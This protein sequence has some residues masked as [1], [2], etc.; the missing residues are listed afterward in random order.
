MAGLGA[1]AEI[2]SLKHDL[3]RLNELKKFLAASNNPGN[4]RRIAEIDEELK[5]IEKRLAELA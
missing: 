3:Q 1:P 2:T 5:R 4:R